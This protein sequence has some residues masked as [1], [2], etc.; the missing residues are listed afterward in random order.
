MAG[1]RI[2]DRVR[3]SQMV[4]DGDAM[5]QPRKEERSLRRFGYVENTYLAKTPDDKGN[6]PVLVTVRWDGTNYASDYHP[7]YLEVCNERNFA[8]REVA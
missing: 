5:F 7:D 6:L 3:F 8:D 4:R 1:F 2:G